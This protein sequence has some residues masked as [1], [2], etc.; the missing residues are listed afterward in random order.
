MADRARGP[1]LDYYLWHFTNEVCDKKEINE[2]LLLIINKVFNIN[3]FKTGSSLSSASVEA[4]SEVG[5]DD[6]GDV[7]SDVKEKI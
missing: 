5:K 7:Q 3:S 4:A 6:G 1:S 2:N